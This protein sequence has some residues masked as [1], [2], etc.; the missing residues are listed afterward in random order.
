MIQHIVLFRFRDEI[1]ERQIAE[2]MEGFGK[3]RET[4]P[5]IASFSWG[6]NNSPEGLNRGHQAGFVMGFQTDEDRARYL[7]HPEHKNYAG[8]VAL[9]L[10]VGGVDGVLVFDYAGEKD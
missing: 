5:E 6:F 1:D 8:N 7:E 4:L 3:L 9:P 10:L 2:V